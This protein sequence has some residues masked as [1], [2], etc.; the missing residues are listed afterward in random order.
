MYTPCSVVARC[1]QLLA[2]GKVVVVVVVVVVGNT[3]VVL[4]GLLAV[5]VSPK[6]ELIAVLV[7]VSCII[8]L[9]MVMTLVM[10]VG[11]VFVHDFSL[12]KVLPLM[13]M[14][15]QTTLFGR[16]SAAG[17]SV[18]LIILHAPVLWHCGGGEG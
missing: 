3:E 17:V 14:L 18:Q 15:L 5:I 2:V 6:M 7:I 12:R 16:N 4:H 1:P 10:V 9:V 13:L 11:I 8:Q